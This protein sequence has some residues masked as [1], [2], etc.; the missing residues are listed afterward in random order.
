MRLVR[1]SGL[2][3]FTVAALP[4][5]SMADPL[6]QVELHAGYG[7]AIS[8]SGDEMSRR[9]TPLTITALTAIGVSVDPPLAGYGGLV[10]ETLDRSAAGTAFGVLLQPHG[11]HLRF[12]AGALYMFAP[13]TLWGVTASL[14]ACAHA[15]QAVALCGDL[16]LTAFV[17]GD[18]LPAGRTVTQGQAVVGLVFDAL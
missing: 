4:A 12:S 14:G 3:L 15:S 9:P 16:Q 8:G 7:L 2:A 5:R 13:A 17:D 1:S 6:V 11:S 18:D 10:I